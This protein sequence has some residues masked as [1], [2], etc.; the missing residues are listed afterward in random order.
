[1]LSRFYKEE[2]L[3]IE[4]NLTDMSLP[5]LLQMICLEERNATLIL[6][7]QGEEGAIYIDGGEITHATLGRI[8]GEEA[9]F[10]LL[11]WEDG[12]FN[13]RN[14]MSMQRRTIAVP[15]D[16][17]VM[18]GMRRIDEA[19][20]RAGSQRQVQDILS[21]K[22]IEAD[23]RLEMDLI[24]LVSKFEY[25]RAKLS[26]EGPSNRPLSALEILIDMV[27]HSQSFCR[28]N[29]LAGGSDFLTKA[30][31]KLGNLSPATRLV[32]LNDS[33]QLSDN[34]IQRYRNWTGNPSSRQET[35]SQVAIILV[36]LLEA[37]FSFFIQKFQ[38]ASLVDQWTE[39]SQVFIADLR[40]AIEELD[41]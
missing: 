21:P 27:N 19:R 2:Q 29:T 39:T 31:T 25:M 28:E 38:A 26:T 4:G 15:R 37:Y 36:S 16:Q 11:T 1:M 5:S 7:H 6:E 8:V 34:L 33:H 3:T 40:H 41:F 10:K 9:V 32:R 23:R 20:V 13:V 18:E 12:A 22:E 14:F 35:F 30:V 17:L 24:G